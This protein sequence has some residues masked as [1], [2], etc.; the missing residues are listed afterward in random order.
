[1]GKRNGRYCCAC[2]LC[3]AGP[4][5][6]GV[7]CLFLTD[8]PDYER[9]LFCVAHAEIVGKGTRAYLAAHPGV[10]VDPECADAW[11]VIETASELAARRAV[12]ASCYGIP[13]GYVP[14]C[15][16]C[17]KPLPCA[18]A[19]PPIVSPFMPPACSACLKPLPCACGTV[20]AGEAPAA[21]PAPA[22]PVEE[23]PQTWRDRP[24]LL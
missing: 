21:V 14:H 23:K 11:A 8:D 24:P 1:M 15:G 17:G 20:I 9:T 12:V 5:A 6:G 7:S 3:A 13:P 16:V 22:P 4:C 19:V 18:C 10:A 2:D